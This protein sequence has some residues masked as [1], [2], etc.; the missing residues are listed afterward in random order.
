MAWK[1]AT[2][3]LYTTLFLAF[4]QVI[5]MESKPDL[6]DISAEEL[7]GPNCLLTVCRGF[8][9]AA[10][11]QEVTALSG[12]NKQEGTTLVGLS[13]AAEAKGL[14]AV[15]MKISAEELAKLACPAIAHLWGD[16]FVVVEGG[17]PPNPD[18][19]LGDALGDT[20]KVTDPLALDPSGPANPRLVP[21]KQ[22]Q[23]GYSGFA[24]LVAEN[25][26]AFPASEPNGPDLRADAYNWDFGFIEQ[27][28]QAGNVFT[29]ENKG[30]EDLVLSKVETSC[31]CT[32]AFLPKESRL[33]PGGKGELVVGFDSAGREGGQSQTVYIYSNDPISP[34]VQLRVGGVIKPT[35]LPVSARSLQFGTITKRDG[36]T[37]VFSIRD[38]G[39]GSLTV[40]EVTSD[41]P[42][43]KATLTR[44]DKQGLEYRVT[45]ELQPG[46]PIGEFKGKITVHS[47]HPKEPVVEIPIAAEVI[48]DIE[49][50]PNQFFLG[51]LKKGQGASKTITLSTTAKERLKVKKIHSPFDYVTVKSETDGK[52][53]VITATLK[54]NAPLGLIKGVVVIHT[55][56]ADQPE[57][58]V[59]L[60]ALVEE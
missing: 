42:F 56:N 39:D 52:Q 50:F 36:S 33:P 11:L 12:F 34:I 38:P 8:G 22:F 25:E 60:Y 44:D 30:V 27:G 58:K 55:N 5:G 53:Y 3:A 48:G 35:R 51:L 16:H 31:T 4:S 23:A 45:V 59:P 13:R 46:A 6:Y 32:L 43:V 17:R 26:S 54:D 9:I 14:H 28:Q 10:T 21:L 57:I 1:T 40:S 49:T 19:A 29:L 41:S 18:D 47:N 20:L 15:G 24:L 37:R 7:C 2:V